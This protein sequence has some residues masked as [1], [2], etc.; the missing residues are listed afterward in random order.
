MRRIFGR[1]SLW[2]RSALAVFWLALSS[3][4]VV[5]QTPPSKAV[6]HVILVSIDGLMPA[7]YLDPDRY[8]LE[9]PTL[10]NLMRTGVAF[11]GAEGVFPTVTY[12]SHTSIITGTLPAEHGIDS[13]TP[14]DPFNRTNGGWYWYAEDLKV[15]T[16][17]DVARQAGK[18]TAS[19]FWPVTVGAN[20]DINYPEYRTLASDDDVKLLRVLATPGLIS[21]IEA[22]YGRI[23]GRRPDDTVR[24]RA[25][26]YIIER[27]RPNLL[28]VH[29]TDLD[30]AQHRSG[31]G[32]AEAMSTLEKI[33]GHLASISQALRQA[34][35][36]ER[37]AWVVVSD[38]GFRRVSRQF[39]P[40]V[41][42]RELGYRTY[43]AKGEL[44]DWRVDARIAGGTF[45][46]V[47]K[48]PA[49][50]EV[51]EIAT[52]KFR[53]LAADTRF[54]LARLYSRAEIGDNGGFPDAF[55]AGEAAD[56]FMIGSA[57]TGDVVTDSTS[58]GMHG[59]HPS[60]PDQLSAL[61]LSGAGIVS[62]QRQDRARLID[63]APTVA[64]LLGVPMATAR[65][66]VL[67]EAL[68]N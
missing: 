60:R 22:R 37:T 7:Y 62:G 68:K 64:R 5:Q 56:E 16:L 66:R 40:H 39:H 38:H 45:S 65:G 32:S 29:L 13:N 11:A 14:F 41:V 31:P 67:T 26:A 28:L 54:G 8:G 48:D 4:V 3:T 46:L 6:D 50:K 9:I 58:K 42:L 15:P 21:G 2:G 59:Y 43:G 36:L 51:V 49:D 35:M 27:H 52:R 63:V 47:A 20:I 53:A 18:T 33:D 25:A 55:L 24:A 44:T 1:E 30:G 57:T 19:V 23:P 34:G 61:L 17:W 10:R 12:P